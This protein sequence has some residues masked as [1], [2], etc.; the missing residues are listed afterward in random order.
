MKNMTFRKSLT[1]AAVAASLGF[2]ALAVAQDAQT[3]VNA[4]E[5]VERIQ[6][7][8]SRI[9]QSDI[10]GA[11]PVSVYTAEDLAKVG[12][13][14]VGDFIQRMPAM[15]GS[16]IGTTTNNGGNGAVTVNLRGLGS[17]RTLVLINGRRT[18]DG[19]DF[20]TI[21]SSMIERIEIL[22]DGA[23]A[24]YG[25]D[26][27]AG[28][29]NVITKKSF[30]GLE[31]NLQY[32]T[33]TET[34]KDSEKTFSIVGGREFEK[35]NI[36]FG[37]EITEQ[38]P[39][40]QGDT[41]FDIF[42][43]PYLGIDGASISNRG[44]DATGDDRNSDILGS[45]SVPCG[46]VITPSGAYI[47]A[48]CQDG[49]G[50]FNSWDGAGYVP[51]RDEF[52]EYVGSGANNDSY[53]YAPVN[54]I[55]TPYTKINVF[56][57][58]EFEI[59]D[60]VQ[61]Y[62][63]LRVNKRSS[64]QRLAATPY[65]TLF[66]PAFS[67]TEAVSADN[68]Y[69]PFDEPVTRIRRR[70]L[71]A[72]REFSQDILQAQ[73]VF[74]I[75][76]YLTDTWSYDVNYNYGYRSRTDVDGGQ[77]SGAR[78]QSALGPSFE[79]A[80]GNIVCGTPDNVIDGCVPMNV[81][82]GNGSITDEMLDY[83]GVSL[84][85]HS[86]SQ[87]DTFNA[88]FSGDL[89]EMPAGWASAAFGY[90][91]RR[92]WSAY[93]PDSGKATGSVTGNTGAGV[94]GSIVVNSLFAEAALPILRDAPA[95]KVLEASLGARY[96][97]FST[98]GGETTLQGGL[99]WQPVD[100]L[101]VRGTYGEVFRAPT[102]GDLYSPQSDSFPSASDPCRAVNWGELTASQQSICVAEGAPQGG[103]AST[104]TQVRARVGGNPDLQPET[105]DT[106]TI[107]VAW[108]PQFFDGFNVTLDWYSI[109]IENVIDSVS[110]QNTLDGCVNGVENL[111]DLITRNP[112]GVIESVVNLSQNLT[113]R[114][115]EG[116]DAE[117]SYNFDTSYGEF[118]T[119]L[120]WTHVLKRENTVVNSQGN[121]ETVDFTG[122][123]DQ[124]YTSETYAEDKANFTVD[125]FID[126][127]SVSYTAEYISGIDYRLFYY[128]T[129]QVSLDSMLYHDISVAYDSEWG[130]RFSLGLTNITDEEPPYI[131]QALNGSTDPSTYRVLGRG[132]FFRVSHKF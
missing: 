45:G 3:D 118:R 108:S 126:N 29:V 109:D 54:F 62:T 22:K 14:D 124:D 47:L 80:D 70:V 40:Y 34:E 7:T 115:A 96:D 71:E 68:Y 57:N 38:T 66:N 121:L 117:F 103:N 113:A 77:F 56:S 87:L 101:L 67:S 61:A 28:V 52:R 107:G 64:T 79:D 25:A 12:I 41:E 97:D 132:A 84:T 99:R 51:S 74:G 123:F 4:E 89:F 55:Q 31:V 35:G 50:S 23:S 85:D 44:P 20:Q 111:C 53:N 15:S 120:G 102:I 63:E 32:R 59:A 98:F 93:D 106:T 13:T 42:Q 100:G 105:G 75:R 10:E 43:N 2:P 81:F 76:G 86:R 69:N 114:K 36:V 24:V 27:V 122:T 21:P 18:V 48:P 129:E 119:F 46:Q 60:D 104:D 26:A 125:W 112:D 49:E 91:Y 8:G 78:L 116:I 130:T 58:A 131:D 30:T 16:P 127:I 11:N 6:V 90:E 73:A 72:P 17:A 19:G 82:G 9:R 110:V 94:E 92:E 39:V 128:P 83:A 65:D 33:S 5:Q 37:A 95:A 1:A 88:S